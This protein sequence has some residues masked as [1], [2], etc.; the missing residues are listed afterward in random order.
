[1]HVDD[2][3][4]RALERFVRPAEILPL[5][6]SAVAGAKAGAFGG[7]IML[8]LLAEHG[9]LLPFRVVAYA[10]SGDSGFADSAAGLVVSAA[11][12]MVWSTGL[13]AVYG[14]V[15]ARLIGRVGVLT[16]ALCGAVFG[17]LAWIISQYVL[18]GYAAPDLVDVNDQ[19]LLAGVHLVYGLCLGF[20]GNPTTN[21]GPG[22]QRRYRLTHNH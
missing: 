11:A 14:L 9:S 18:I 4:R 10:L 16:A 21:A 3:S 22:L 15:I 19:S 7:M 13:G 17:L 1:M 12:Y 20:L 8:F 2:T 5:G 6:R